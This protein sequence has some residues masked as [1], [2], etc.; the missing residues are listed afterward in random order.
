[1]KRLAAA[2]GVLILLAGC[3]SSG[4]RQAGDEDRPRRPAGGSPGAAAGSSNPVPLANPDETDSAPQGDEIP[5]DVTAIP[6]AVPQDEARSASGNP[7]SYVVYG[8]RYD[9]LDEAGG[10][11]E[12]GYASWYGKKFHGKRTSSG[13]PY[14]M[15]AMTA[16]HKTLP[17]PSYVRVTRVATG[18]SVVVKINDRGPFHK[19]RII[20]LSYAAAAK[21]GILDKGSALVDVAVV[22]A[23]DPGPAHPGPEPDTASKQPDD[24]TGV[25]ATSAPRYLQ[26]GVFADAANATAFR[27]QLAAAGIEPLLMKSEKRNERWVYRIL[28]GPFSD[29]GS[30]AET[31]L[32]LNAQ[33]T[34]TIPVSD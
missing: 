12:R 21:L 13:A 25:A 32:R 22:T 34:Q 2:L 4:H 30:L 14:D 20:D 29:G 6:D 19:G 11:H 9:V 24:S 31:R 23:E 3:A 28:I 1:M 10:Y 18:K 27:N 33:A 17:I 7:D 5:P 26:A 8:K 16:A 15:F